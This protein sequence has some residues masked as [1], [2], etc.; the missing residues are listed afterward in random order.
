[1]SDR[2]QFIRLMSKANKEQTLAV[3]AIMYSMPDDVVTEFAE[4]FA[5]WDG[6][7]RGECKRAI[8]LCRI[9]QAGYSRVGDAEGVDRMERAAAKIRAYLHRARQ[10]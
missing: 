4:R 6:Y 9:S 3:W 5:G 7:T 1:M 8:R 10:N 2:E